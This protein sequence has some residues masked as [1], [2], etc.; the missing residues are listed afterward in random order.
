MRA[1]ACRVSI[2]PIPLAPEVDQMVLGGDT[3]AVSSI[4]CEARFAR[5]SAHKKTALL[6]LGMVACE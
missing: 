2:R 1:L 5:S 3:Q 6:P 4:S